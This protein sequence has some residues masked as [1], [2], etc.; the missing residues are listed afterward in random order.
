MKTWKA[1]VFLNCENQL[2]E[3]PEWEP[4]TNIFSWVDIMGKAVHTY[5][6]SNNSQDKIEVDNLVGFAIPTNQENKYVLGMV[7]EL[8][9]LDINS[10]NIELLNTIPFDT[11]FQRLNDGKCDS[12]G[13]L[14]SGTQTSDKENHPGALYVIEKNKDIKKAFSGVGC[15]NG[16]CWSS[17]NKKMF[18]IDT[19]TLTLRSYDYEIETGEFSNETVILEYPK[20][21]GFLD[22]MTIDAEDKLWVALWNGSKVIRFCPETKTIIGEIQVDARQVTSMVF[23]GDNLDKLLITTA[24]SGIDESI[25]KDQPNNGNLFICETN[26]P[27]KQNNQFKL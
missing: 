17:D 8:N 9:I 10:K 6:F 5:D 21:N 15:S 13:R 11:N 7:N 27:G 24:R 2:G 25:L 20:E 22:G 4:S 14:W 3:G 1:D 18:Y 19:T 16:Q 23:A 26:I 12:K